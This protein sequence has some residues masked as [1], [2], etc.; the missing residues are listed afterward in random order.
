[1][2]SRTLYISYKVIALIG[3]GN[4][5]DIAA[6]LV[7]VAMNWFVSIV[8]SAYGLVASTPRRGEGSSSAVAW[9]FVF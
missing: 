7:Y 6:V 8:S 2:H 3:R 9:A 1:M 4:V 5:I